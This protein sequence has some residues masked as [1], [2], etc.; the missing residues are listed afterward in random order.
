[1]NGYAVFSSVRLH[2]PDLTESTQPYSWA[3]VIVYLGG[4][5]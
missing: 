3:S 5:Q 1:M 2:G 4:C